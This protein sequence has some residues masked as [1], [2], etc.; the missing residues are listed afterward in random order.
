MGFKSEIKELTHNNPTAFLIQ[1]YGSRR[2][3]FEDCRRILD[4]NTNEVVIEGREQVKITGSGLRLLELGGRN[5]AVLG[6]LKTIE[7][8]GKRGRRTQ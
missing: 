5:L 8:L 6:T 1:I 7:F 2:V 3:I 4:Y